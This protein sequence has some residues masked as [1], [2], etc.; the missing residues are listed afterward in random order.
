MHDQGTVKMDGGI[1]TD[2]DCKK[3]VPDSYSEGYN[4]EEVNESTPMY[5][6]SDIIRKYQLKTTSV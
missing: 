3:D 1:N 2:H 6:N 5:A 4:M